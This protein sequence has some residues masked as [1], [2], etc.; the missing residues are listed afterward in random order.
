M[1]AEIRILLWIK[2]SLEN[3]PDPKPWIRLS[4]SSHSQHHFTAPA[5]SLGFFTGG[6]VFE[7]LFLFVKTLYS[8]LKN[9]FY[10]FTCM[11]VLSES[12]S[13]FRVPVALRG[14]KGASALLELELWMAA[15]CMWLLGITPRSSAGADNTLNHRAISPVLYFYFRVWSTITH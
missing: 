7:N 11:G 9:Y 5:Q 6:R 13:V 12:M 8:S 10:R 3:R 14:Q 15:S 2:M 4:L 1:G